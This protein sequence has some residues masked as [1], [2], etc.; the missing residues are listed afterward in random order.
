MTCL[1]SS[2]SSRRASSRDLSTSRRQLRSSVTSFWVDDKFSSSTASLCSF[3]SH[4]RFTLTNPTNTDSVTK[5]TF[6][7]EHNCIHLLLF[8]SSY[9]I[10]SVSALRR[11]SLRW[12]FDWLRVSLSLV[13]SPRLRRSSVPSLLRF[14]AASWVWLRRRSTSSKSRLRWSRLSSLAEREALHWSSWRAKV[15]CVLKGDVLLT[16][17]KMG[18]LFNYV[19]PGNAA[20]LVDNSLSQIFFFFTFFS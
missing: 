5:I 2:W 1:R 15:S 18:E 10:L 12:V 14:S 8:A 20:C 13:T 7:S 6:S 19:H 11:I 17:Q 4:C 9:L 16:E 3:S